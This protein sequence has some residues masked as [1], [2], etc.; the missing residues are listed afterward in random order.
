MATAGATA[1]AAATTDASA[2]TCEPGW[3]YGIGDP[4]MNGR[5]LALEVYEE[6][7][8]PALFAGGFFSTAGGV[9]SEGVARWDGQ[10]WS[11]TSFESE[12]PILTML[13]Y[14][15]GSG[16]KLYVGGRFNRRSGGAITDNIMRWDGTSWEP[17]GFGLSEGSV[18][19][20]CVFDDGS[21]PALYAGGDFEKSGRDPMFGI[22]RWDG[23][24]WSAVGSGIFGGSVFDMAV[25]DNGT[26]PALYVAGEF[27]SVGGVFSPRIARWDGTEWTGVDGGFRTWWVETLEVFDD[28][29]GEALYAG[30]FFFQAGSVRADNIAR[31]YDTEWTTVGDGLDDAVYDLHVF[32]DGT[33]PA[34]YAAGAFEN[35]GD[36]PINYIAKWDGEHWLPLGIGTDTSAAAMGTF[37]D[38]NGPA[39]YVGGF[40][41]E[42]GGETARNM[43][44][45]RGC[46]E[47]ACRA[48][49][50][51]DSAL[52]IF[53][54]LLFQ[55][56]FDATDP[57]ADFDGDGSLSIF[58]F[59]AFQN[60]FDA[61]CP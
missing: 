57:V 10:E 38:G 47:P 2:Q 20:L 30:G 34:L 50:D 56:L 13:T 5:V 60:E 16:P 59:L 27:S 23:T 18:S 14:D 32:D 12:N 55:N 43:A 40:F 17:A 45:W 28:G 61:G 22:A 37:D 21:G 29:S 35:S 11:Q 4:G 1:I 6:P 9:R 41:T 36:D 44:A 58:D 3:E 48:D 33:Q 31:L 46:P 26:G 39:L 24:K 42:A 49:L 52:T 54:F 8:G 51:G 19:A 7:D 25:F 15:D 53:D